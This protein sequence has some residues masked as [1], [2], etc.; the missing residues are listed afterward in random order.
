MAEAVAVVGFVSNIVQLVDFGSKV[1]H[2]LNDFQTSLGETPKVF[3]HINKELPL[4][5]DTLKQT[6]IAVDKGT[7]RDETKQALVPVVDGCRT[8]IEL[9]DNIVEKVL[10]L[11]GDSW[12]RKGN[13]AVT[14]LWQDS[15][16]KNITTTLRNYIHTL[17]YYHAATS[18]TL[19]AVNGKFCPIGSPFHC[20][21]H[22]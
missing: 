13:K 3:R 4:L 5:L 2:R 21:L 10:P 6:Q 7:I 17:T 20:Q 19:H 11:P 16:V 12:R 18:S 22:A 9:L 14:S 15:K 8:Q 1:L